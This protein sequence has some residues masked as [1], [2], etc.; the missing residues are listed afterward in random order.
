MH[1]PTKYGEILARIQQIDPIQYGSTRNYLGG[2]ITYLSPYNRT[3][4][5]VII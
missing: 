1:F 4:A 5:A 3:L 2:A